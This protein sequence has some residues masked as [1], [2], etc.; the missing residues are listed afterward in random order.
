MTIKL[1]PPTKLGL[2]SLL[3][4]TLIAGGFAIWNRNKSPQPVIPEPGEVHGTQNQLPNEFPSD[5]PIFKPATI[6]SSTKSQERVHLV[7]ETEES[8]EDVLTFY[9]KKMKQAGWKGIETFQPQGGEAWSYSKD[10]QRFELIAVRNETEGKTL[11]FLKTN[12]P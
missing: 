9:Q 2:L 7:L 1:S 6:R 8:L 12:L 4:L 11:I 3:S 5:I 10:G